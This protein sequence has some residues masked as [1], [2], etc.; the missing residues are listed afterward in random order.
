MY[1][2]YFNIHSTRWMFALLLGAAMLT[3]CNDFLDVRPKSEK[4]EDDLFQNAD[5]FESAIYGVYGSMQVTNLY[6][7]ELYWGL[8]DV[9]SQ[10]LKQD[11]NT[12]STSNYA[13]AH[14]NYS[15]NDELK[16]RFSN[17]WTAAYTS[18]G[19]ANN[20]LKNLEGRSK[21]ELP[22]YNLYKGEMLAVRAYLHFDLLRLFAST[23]TEKRG[24]PYTT[25]YSPSVSEFKKVGE[26]YELILQDLLQAEQLLSE[27]KDEMV[28]P[29]NNSQ[30]FKFQNYRETHCNYYA[31]LGLLAKVYWMKGDMTNAAKYAQMVIDSKKFPLADVAEIKDLF[32]GKLSDKETLWGLYSNS[33]TKTAGATLY[34]YQ[35][36]TT[37]NP[38]MDNA[39]SKKLMPYNKVYTQ[40]VET[41]AQDYRLNWFNDN[42]TSVSCWKT[43]D[44]YTYGNLSTTP[45]NWANRIDGINMLHVSELYLIAAEALLDTDYAKAVEYFNAETSSRGL[46]LLTADQQLTKERIFN[47]YHKEMFGEGQVWYN[48]KRLGKDITSNAENKVIPANDDVYVVPIP[49]DE[50][51]YRN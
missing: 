2:R 40:D 21:S 29:R 31:V 48:M 7:K 26:D 43:L 32:A 37:Y 25:T 30:Y 44:Y 33:Y 5:G 8:T 27:E 28:Y 51:D 22:L 13:L 1:K 19:Y 46:P 47:E 50:F 38:Y 6:G 49:Q 36:N 10:D 18:I 4:V 42:T 34:S 3:S 14:Y 16:T 39:Q 35:T 45:E 9:M 23:D 12:T 11:A 15:G 20:V 24:I 17:V 41:T